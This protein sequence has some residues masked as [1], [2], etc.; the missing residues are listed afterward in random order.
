MAE[1]SKPLIELSLSRLKT[2]NE[3]RFFHQIWA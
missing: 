1:K 2:V 3:T